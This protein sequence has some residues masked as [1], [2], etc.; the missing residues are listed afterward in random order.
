MKKTTKT[1][2]KKT[3]N[4]KKNA[5]KRSERKSVS[6][7][8]TKVVQKKERIKVANELREISN[9]CA[10]KTAAIHNKWAQELQ[11]VKSPKT[12][13]QINTKYEQKLER[14]DN[15]E[16]KAYKN[17]YDYVHKNFSP[18]EIVSAKPYGSFNTKHFIN[19]LNKTSK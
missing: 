5:A 1:T 8:E 7:K 17:Y 11:G 4:N 6:K 13:E 9:K 2:T 16:N 14:A 18:E 12:R 10:N 3:T 15:M 19:R